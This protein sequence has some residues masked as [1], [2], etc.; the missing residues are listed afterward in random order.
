ME[1]IVDEDTLKI[2]EE[3]LT[4][5]ALKTFDSTDEYAKSQQLCSSYE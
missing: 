3:K 4:Q 2:W 5:D 1:L